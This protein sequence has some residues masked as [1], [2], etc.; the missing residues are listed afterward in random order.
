MLHYNF[1]PYSVGEVRRIGSP[2]RREV[3]HGALAERAIA[4]VLPS[5]DDFPYT[6][7]VVCEA[8]GS[9]G[10]T[11][12]ASVCAGTLA[13]MDAG[14]P[15]KAPVAGISVGLIDGGD[16][17]YVTITDIQGMEDHVGDMDFK[18][19]GT[20]EG[21]TAIQ[22]DIKVNSISFDVVKD[23]LDQAKEARLFILDH[24]R[25]T[26]SDTRQDLSPFAPRML[27]I[28]VPVDK[29]GTVIGPRRQD[30]SRH[31]RGDGCND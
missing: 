9:N 22:L 23:A 31:H 20:R 25:E 14:V 17:E 3:G 27:Q 1:P 28:N 5:Q 29:I 12:M 4:P 13:L 16:G 6:L 18:V 8:L 30:D 10:S 2:G 21:I 15:I 7:R 26:I 19:A 11:S 24:M